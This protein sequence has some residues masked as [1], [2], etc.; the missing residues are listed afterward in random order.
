MKSRGGSGLL[1]VSRA[2][3][4]RAPLTVCALQVVVSQIFSASVV[5]PPNFDQQGG[6]L[7]DHDRQATRPRKDGYADTTLG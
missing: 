4:Q 6:L 3:T 1:V 2:L 5:V 7:P